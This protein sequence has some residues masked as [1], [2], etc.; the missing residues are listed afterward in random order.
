[1]KILT[2]I[3][4]N[5]SERL[6][7]FLSKTIGKVLCVTTD[8]ASNNDTMMAAIERLTAT[9]SNPFDSSL[10]YGDP[11]STGGTLRKCQV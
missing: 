2:M 5:V 6:A 8:N 10:V 1:M 11:S 9:S 4:I 7:K 3:S